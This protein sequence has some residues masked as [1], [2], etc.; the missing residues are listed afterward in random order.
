MQ[1]SS[2]T[3][4]HLKKIYGLTEMRNQNLINIAKQLS[5][6]EGTDLFTTGTNLEDYSVSLA[7]THLAP[8]NGGGKRRSLKNNRKKKRSKKLIKI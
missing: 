7:E 3:L 1:E 4:P 6:I 5:N 2:Q 8:N